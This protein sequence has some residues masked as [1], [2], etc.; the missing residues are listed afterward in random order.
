MQNKEKI[1]GYLLTFTALYEPD[2]GVEFAQFPSKEY[3]DTYRTDVLYYAIS[4][5]GKKYEPLNNKKAVMFPSGCIKLGSPS[6]FRKADGSYGLIADTDESTSEVIIF[7]SD[8][9]LYFKNQRTVSLRSDN[10]P[11]IAPAAF[12]SGDEY[13]IFFFDEEGNSFVTKTADFCDFSE[14][15]KTEYEKETL[16][17]EIPEFAVED[18]ASVFELT[19]EEY[20]RIIRKYGK[21]SSVA[22]ENCDIEAKE[23][24]EVKLPETVN[25][26][27]S[28]GSKTP[29]KVKWD[30]KNLDL[31]SLSAG[32]YTVNGK[33][34]AISEYNSP[35]A[36][37]RADPYA[38]YDEENDVYYFTGSN[39]NENS[40][41]GGGA[42]TSI[43]IRRSKT[44]NGIT[45]A[46][47]F[48]IWCDGETPDGT[49]VT[50]W[51]WAPEIH[52]IG[53]KWRI[54]A[55]ATVTEKG[56]EKGH[57][58]QCIFTCN[59]DD[60]TKAENWE[61]TGYI[62]DTP[63]GQSVGS[64][65]TTYFEYGGKSYY[66]TPKW[67][68]LWITTVDPENPLY[69]TSPLVQISV[70]DKA[71]ETNIG[72]G[73][74]GWGNMKNG[75][76]GQAIE[77]ASS[78]LIH[79]GKIFN[80]Y[81]GCTI[82][83]MYC[84][85]AIYADLDSDLLDPKSWKKYPYPL[86]AT[87]DLTKTVKKADY[88]KTDG[89]TKVTGS[90]DS[91]LL[92]EA[93]GEYVGIFGPG[94]NSFTVDEAGNPVIIYHARDWSDEYPGAVGPDKY[95]LV[96]PGRHAYAKPVIF[97]YEG[98]PVCNLTPEEYLKDELRDVT[99]KITVK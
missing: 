97:N 79:G 66:M 13:E 40:A 19:E 47:E 2:M 51:Y 80:V 21:L 81:A 99:V 95:G 48:D 53:G 10:K 77:E 36:D 42:Y 4:K 41:C 16:N 76:I 87:Q 18:E 35:L 39:M 73:K 11:V 22:V 56:E 74:C 55:L 78:I 85:C 14:P 27:Y 83:M 12:C 96:D 17:A 33:I 59:G 31:T 88:S 94:H 28:D 67:A 45:D 71:F 50:G 82:D 86:L 46:E 38:V 63:D 58:R 1:G 6:L 25:V 93:L 68:S 70:A 20:E 60:L 65:D 23:N 91:G 26:V 8:D 43:M 3:T 52:K 75:K 54:I 5:D 9:L 57:G 44:I 34:T 69:P 15:V 30:A 84:V 98:Y 7:D 37:C 64:F 32:E 24:E 72:P 29:M 62:H 90:G 61:Y 89:T 92:P 49:K